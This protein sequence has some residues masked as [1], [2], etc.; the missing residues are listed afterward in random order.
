ME[1][2]RKSSKFILEKGMKSVGSL[3]SLGLLLFTISGRVD[4]LGFL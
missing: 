2:S 4:I 1:H 3:A